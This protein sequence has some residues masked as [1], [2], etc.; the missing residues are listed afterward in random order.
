M[1]NI[2]QQLIVLLLAVLTLPQLGSSQQSI[3]TELDYNVHRVYPYLSLTKEQLKEAKTIM[4]LNVKYKPSWVRT[5]HSVEVLASH[6]GTIKSAISKDET[7]S[8]EQKDLMNM[9]DA[10]TDITVKVHYLP[11]NTLT[12]NEDK[13]MDFTF[14]VSPEKEAKYPKGQAQM[15]QYLQENAINQIPA[16]LFTGYKLA[17]LKFT[18]TEEGEITNAHVFESSRDE[19]VD[20]LLLE[21][22]RKMPCWIPAEYANGHKVKQEFA[23][24]VGN[25]KSCVINLLNIRADGLPASIAE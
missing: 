4:D 12:H 20:A 23:L 5:Y 8:Q 22:I 14:A 13:M 3:T 9:A 10:G 11:E 21:T 15:M 25:M 2:H 18:V 17:A 16:D 6:N 1:K 19:K 7:L 24:A